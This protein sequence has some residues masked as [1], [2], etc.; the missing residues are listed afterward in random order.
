MHLVGFITKKFVTMRGHINVKY[1]TYID[2]IKHNG[3]D[4]L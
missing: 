3:D 2:H 4:P 1:T